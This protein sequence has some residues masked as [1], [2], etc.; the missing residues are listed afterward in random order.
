MENLV[1]SLAKGNAMV[2]DQTCGINLLIQF[3]VSVR[4]VE[5]KTEG[6]HCTHLAKLL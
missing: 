6:L 1:V 4:F 2:V 5:F 3:V